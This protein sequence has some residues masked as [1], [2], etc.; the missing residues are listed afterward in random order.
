MPLTVDNYI[1]AN[2]D[3]YI[4]AKFV[5]PSTGNYLIVENPANGDTI[6]TVGVSGAKDV[7]RA[8]AAAER[9]FPAW[10]K[11]TIK[12]RAAIMMKFH[13][14]VKRHADE[15]ADLIVLENGKNKTEALA[16]GKTR[17]AVSFVTSLV[18]DSLCFLFSP[19]FPFFISMK[20]CSGQGK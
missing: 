8:V 2:I 13:S 14:L 7:D 17:K 6:G 9:A 1:D 4:D 12:G 10:S 18:L 20:S 16:D 11:L 19:F 5:E 15:L 3:N